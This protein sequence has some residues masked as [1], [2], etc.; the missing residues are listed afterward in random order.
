M[1]DNILLQPLKR[2][3]APL[4]RLV[5]LHG[6]IVLSGLLPSQASATLAAYRM[7][8][9][10]LERRI[11]IEGWATLVLARRRRCAAAQRPRLRGGSVTRKI[12]ST[13]AIAARGGHP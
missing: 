3:A 5:A 8:G 13:G 1:F 12:H 4:A 2:L 7:Q 6:R 9:L 11:L 10:A